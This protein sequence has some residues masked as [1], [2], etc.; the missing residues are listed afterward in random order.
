[1]HVWDPVLI[2]DIFL[3]HSV[4]LWLGGLEGLEIFSSPMLRDPPKFFPTHAT[5]GEWTGHAMPCKQPTTSVGNDAKNV[6]VSVFS[7]TEAQQELSMTPDHSIKECA[8]R[9]PYIKENWSSRKIIMNYKK[10]YSLLYI[11]IVHVYNSMR[12]YYYAIPFLIYFVKEPF[13]NTWK[14]TLLKTSKDLIV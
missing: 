9:K 11:H 1:M 10:L 3:F 12:T 5:G 14:L 7:K 6:G 8:K 2:L 4:Q 13:S